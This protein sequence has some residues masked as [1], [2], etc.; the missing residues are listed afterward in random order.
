VPAPAGTFGSAGRN[1]VIGPR[2]NIADFSV[3]KSTQLN[4]RFHLQFRSDFFNFFNHPNLALPNFTVNSS[5]F[6]TIAST[7]DVA[8]GI[9][10]GTAA[11]GS[12]SSR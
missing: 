8:N 4:E 12:S 2:T 7:V 11:R 9:R 3:V 1:T 5:A 10:L 6:G